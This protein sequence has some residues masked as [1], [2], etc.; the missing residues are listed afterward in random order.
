MANMI[1]DH[2]EKHGI[3]FIRECVPTKVEK[4]S[5]GTPGELKVKFV[6]IFE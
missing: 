2:M 1:G 3:K 6:F 5:E 4:I